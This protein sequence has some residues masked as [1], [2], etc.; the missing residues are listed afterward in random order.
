MQMI[1]IG[2][3][4]DYK[5]YYILS[6]MKKVHIHYSFYINIMIS[7]LMSRLNEHVAGDQYQKSKFL[8]S[9]Y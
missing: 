5:I 8:D 6:V 4:I 2:S 7:K 9:F 1:T 3:D